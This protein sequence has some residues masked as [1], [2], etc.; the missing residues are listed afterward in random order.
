MLPFLEYRAAGLSVIP[1]GTDKRPLIGSWTRLQKELPSEDEISA[2][3]SSQGIAVIAGAV[4]GNLV[5]VDVDTKHDSQGTVFQEIQDT[6]KEWG[7]TELLEKCAIERTPSGG[8]HIL[9]RAPFVVGC[10]KLARDKGQKE[11]MIET[12]GEG[13]YF[14]CA[15]TPGWELKHG[16]LTEIPT[17]KDT[18]ANAILGVCWALDRN[19]PEVEPEPA[20][21]KAPSGHGNGPR[22]GEVTPLDDFTARTTVEAV[23][24]L[25]C[26][27][28]WRRTGV[29]GRNI[30]LCRPGKGGRE[31]SATLHTEKNVFFVH[32]TSTEFRERKGYGPAGVYAIL[33]HG[34][35]W[36]ATAKDLAAQGYGTRREKSKPDNHTKAA[37]IHREKLLLDMDGLDKEIFDAF[38][39]GEDTG[40]A[41]EWPNFDFRLADNQM[42]VVTGYP[43]SGKSTF[44][45]SIAVHHAKDHF[46]RWVI[47]SMEDYPNRRLAGKLIR[48]YIR[49]AMYGPHAMTKEEYKAGW[50]WVKKHFAFVNAAAENITATGIIQEVTALNKVQKVNGLILDPWS[51]MDEDR[52]SDMTETDFIKV[53]LKNVRKFCRAETVHTIILAHP[54]KPQRG[55]SG[56]Y[57]TLN[58]YDIAGS[59]HW[60]AKADNG[61][62]VRRDF[63][64]NTTSVDI[65]KVKF[66]AY[67]KIGST[68]EFR[69]DI[70][71]ECYYPITP[72]QEFLGNQQEQK[73][74]WWER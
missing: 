63:E 14:V 9:F 43:S 19:E 65:Q 61:F 26:E 64:N 37:P 2:W 52:P 53:S 5:C 17:L 55:K 32:S 39:K 22:S 25:L 58:L 69:F 4:S 44:V 50:A 60:R 24:S 15:P 74:E 12:K 38:D 36:T 59:H 45:Q 54:T 47:A 6:L 1:V 33:K 8:W 49:K 18:E 35:N 10:E 41:S 27:H 34:G 70:P 42:T 62:I 73:D 28:G 3:G 21:Y 16:S 23:E 57:H 56:E 71:T 31:T 11:A 51:E 46:W 20:A 29:R 67:G 68:A 72:A 13:G 30:H 48:K 66:G 40:L 7:H